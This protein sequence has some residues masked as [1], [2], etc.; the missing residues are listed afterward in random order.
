MSKETKNYMIGVILGFVGI[1][2]YVLSVTGYENIRFMDVVDILR[3]L[4]LPFIF[5]EL[6]VAIGSEGIRNIKEDVIYLK[7]KLSKK[8]TEEAEQ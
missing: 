2:L 8:S 1:L 3:Q 4:A 5:T 7:K 6:W